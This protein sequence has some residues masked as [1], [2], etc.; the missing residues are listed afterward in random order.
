MPLDIQKAYRLQGNQDRT[1]QK[2]WGWSKKHEGYPC[3]LGIIQE[4][5][6]IIQQ[7]LY[8][9]ENFPTIPKEN[10]KLKPGLSNKHEDYINGISTFSRLKSWCEYR[11]G[12]VSSYLS[13]FLF[14]VWCKHTS[15][16]PQQLPTSLNNMFVVIPS[17]KMK[18]FLMLPNMCKS[19]LAP[20]FGVVFHILGKG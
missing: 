1:I 13:E 4:I 19:P 17:S 6:E 9:V 14:L 15:M 3:C 18:H 20:W 11:M 2:S 10:S 7:N 12:K 5:M 16:Y 8:F